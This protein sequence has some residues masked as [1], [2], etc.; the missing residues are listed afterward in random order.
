MIIIINHDFFFI[1]SIYEDYR[2]YNYKHK[3]NNNNNIDHNNNKDIQRRER[4]KKQK[5]STQN[6]IGKRYVYVYSAGP[7]VIFA[8]TADL[9]LMTLIYTVER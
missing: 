1:S 9:I 8:A 5:P 7:A 6:T 3:S 2:Q 4:E